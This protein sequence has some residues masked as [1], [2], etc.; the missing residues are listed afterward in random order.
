MKGRMWHRCGPLPPPFTTRSTHTTHSTLVHT[1]DAKVRRK[2]LLERPVLSTKPLNDPPGFCSSEWGSPFST[3]RPWSSTTT[4]AD[5]RDDASELKC[6]GKYVG[7]QTS[8]RRERH[9]AGSGTG[10]RHCGSKCGRL[11]A[12]LGCFHGRP[13][14]L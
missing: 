11:F 10:N 2:R 9:A 1:C 14:A 6:G 4:C 12:A 8:A 5:A 7:P 13:Q 3:T